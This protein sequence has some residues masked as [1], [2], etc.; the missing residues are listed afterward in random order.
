MKRDWVIYVLLFPVAFGFF[1]NNQKNYTKNKE[2]QLNIIDHPELLP[3]PEIA[4]LSSFGFNN[5]FADIYWLQAIQYIGAN[6]IDTEYKKYLNE[7]IGIIT[8]LNPYFESPYTIGQ[9]LLPSSKERFEDY[10]GKNITQD[11]LD[12]KNLWLKWIHNFCDN[13]KIQLIENEDHLWKIISEEKFKNPCAGYKIPYYLAYIY[14]FYLKEPHNASLYYKVVAAQDDA[15]QWAK[16]LAAIMQGKTWDRQKSLFMFLSL[17]QSTSNSQNACFL[18]AQ[19]L[20]N[21]YDALSSWEMPLTGELVKN[22]EDLRLQIFPKFS[23]ENEEELFDTTQCSSYLL[24]A[25]R[26]FNLLYLDIADQE[27]IAKNPNQISAMNPQ[28]LLSNWFIDFIPTD[29]QQYEDYWMTYQYN[30]EIERFDTQMS[31]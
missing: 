11:M 9:L 20:E 1:F 10:S 24:K 12:G 4:K 30:A 26:E 31:Y 3:T 8:E 28:T 18:F 13:T 27:Y 19:E 29:Y 5:M 15:P 22:I 7:M 6:V 23:K 25:V 21:V 14:Y 2:L 17:A 16:T